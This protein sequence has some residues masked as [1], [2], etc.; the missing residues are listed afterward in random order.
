MNND[1][2]VDKSDLIQY[3]PISCKSCNRRIGKYYKTF[4]QAPNKEKYF[5]E[6]DIMR[7]CCRMRFSFLYV[8]TVD[9]RKLLKYIEQARK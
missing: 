6:R 9:H 3:M 7:L 4:L 1:L 5:E 2:F 8:D